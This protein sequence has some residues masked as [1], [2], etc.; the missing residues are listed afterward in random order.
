MGPWKEDKQVLTF[1][2]KEE[3]VAAVSVGTGN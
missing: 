3:E 2:A 1:K